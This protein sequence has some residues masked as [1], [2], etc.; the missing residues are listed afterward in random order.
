MYRRLTLVVALLA[1]S[2]SGCGTATTSPTEAVTPSSAAM[3][4]P[5]PSPLPSAAPSVPTASPSSVAV[6]SPTPLSRDEAITNAR[7]F[8]IGVNTNG[9]VRTAAGPYSQFNPTP[10]AKLSPPPPDHWVW[11]VTFDSG[12]TTTS[13]V[14][15]DYYTGSFIEM[16][17]GTP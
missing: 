3:P 4:I 16:G 10:N 17:V 9:M 14:I 15:V 2:A 7:R 12:R 6:A 1:V 8:A 5:S 11:Q 13:V